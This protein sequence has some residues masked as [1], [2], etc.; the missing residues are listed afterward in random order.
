M[1]NL[2]GKSFPK[3]CLHVDL[4][5]GKTP[6]KNQN[7][8]SY[9]MDHKTNSKYEFFNKSRSKGTPQRKHFHEI[10]KI[11]IKKLLKI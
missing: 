5:F 11:K 6:E 1:F 7:Y 8:F 9:D 10:L 3:K 2:I 4:T